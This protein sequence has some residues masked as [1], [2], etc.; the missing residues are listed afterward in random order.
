MRQPM[1]YWDSGVARDKELAETLK[2]VNVLLIKRYR[3][4]NAGRRK[5]S[6][7]RALRKCWP[8]VRQALVI[9]HGEY[10]AT[11]HSSARG[12]SD[13]GPSIPF[14]L[15]H[16]PARRSEKIQLAQATPS[17]G[18]HGLLS[19]RSQNWSREVLKLLSILWRSDGIFRGG[20]VLARAAAIAIRTDGGNRRPLPA[21]S[22]EL[23]HLE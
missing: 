2:L 8:W 4:Q 15:A 14:A 3:D 12:S 1:N 16:L 9:K 20:N 6:A 5:K 17:P 23:D 11:N 18:V 19:I 13:C 22:A 21:Y 10:G 7:A